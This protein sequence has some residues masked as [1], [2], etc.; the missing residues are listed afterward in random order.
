MNN[1]RTKLKGEVG[2]LFLVSSGKNLII[3]SQHF[4]I[5]VV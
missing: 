4:V 5:Q 1:I 2:S 3:T